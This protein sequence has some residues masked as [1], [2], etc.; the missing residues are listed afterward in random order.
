[1]SEDSLVRLVPSRNDAL[2][3]Y[4]VF[5]GQ[6]ALVDLAQGTLNTL[7]TTATRVWQL[8]GERVTVR[9]IAERICRE[10][11]VLSKEAINDVLAVLQEM[12]S[13]GWI[14]NFPSKSDDQEIAVGRRQY[15]DI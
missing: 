5:D 15:G 14:N 12:A 9:K 2:L 6:T 10:F 11:G 3:A 13:R 4:R 8:V 1:M 7:N